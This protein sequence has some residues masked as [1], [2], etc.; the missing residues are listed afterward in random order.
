MTEQPSA[1][2][3]EQRDKSR[4]WTF[5][6]G[7]DELTVEHSFEREDAIHV[8]LTREDEA[9]VQTKRIYEFAN[10]AEAGQ[11]HASLDEFLLQF[12]WVFIGYLPNR[13]SH[14]DR[15]H[16]IRPSDRRRWWTD[17]GTFLE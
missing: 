14:Q 17:G 2:D 16:G 12:G 9:G 3:G 5:A 6:K 15:R 4:M 10:E 8:T 13:R 11:F 1:N 7:G